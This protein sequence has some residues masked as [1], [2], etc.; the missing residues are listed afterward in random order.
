MIAARDEFGYVHLHVAPTNPTESRTLLLLHGTGGTEHDLLEIG[1]AVMPGAR[2]LSPRG[3]VLEGS[4]A[5]FFRRLAEGVFDEADVIRRAG[6]LAAF[7]REATAAYGADP[8]RVTALG[9]SNGANIAAA[10]MLLHPTTLSG[11]VLMR[12]M[13][14][15][16]PAVPPA[17]SGRRVLLLQGRADPIVPLAN[18]EALAG[19]L[20]D[21]GAEVQFHAMEAGHGISPRDVGLARVWTA[22]RDADAA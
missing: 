15:L 13:V 1:T 18:G 21:G 22:G 3:N 12:A 4:M 14:P 2:I 10:L 19:M 6:E 9:F 17:L 20:R 8:T 11:A 5:R 7:V 16:T